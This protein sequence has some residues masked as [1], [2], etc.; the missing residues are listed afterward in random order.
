MPSGIDGI[1]VHMTITATIGVIRLPM[2]RDNFLVHM[3]TTAT[4][5]VDSPANGE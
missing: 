2:A 4:I 5:V 1:L 3:T